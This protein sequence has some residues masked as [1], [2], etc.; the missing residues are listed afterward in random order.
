MQQETV[1]LVYSLSGKAYQYAQDLA[2]KENA[3]C[4]RIE[5]KHKSNFLGYMLLG[6]AAVLKKPIQLKPIAHD[7]SQVERCIVVSPV[8][9][10][11]ICAPVRSFLFSHRSFLKNIDLILTHSSEDQLY[12]EAAEMIEKELIFK[13][14]SVQSIT[15]K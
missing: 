3:V 11:R 10:G 2:I 7:L 6:Y 5:T 14:N 9:A 13:F 1:V 12:L 15:L 8:H 4:V